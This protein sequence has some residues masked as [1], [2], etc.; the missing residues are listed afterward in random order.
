MKTVDQP[1]FAMEFRSADGLQKLPS[2]RPSATRAQFLARHDAWSPDWTARC[3]WG[4]TELGWKSTTLGQRVFAAR[5]PQGYF[6]GPDL[7]LLEDAGVYRVHR[8]DFFTRLIFTEPS[9]LRQEFAWGDERLS[10]AELLRPAGEDPQVDWGSLGFPGRPLFLGANAAVRTGGSEVLAYKREGSVGEY[11]GT[12]GPGASGSLTFG[13][14][15]PADF[16]AEEVTLLGL[17]RRG[18]EWVL[19]RETGCAPSRLVRRGAWL[20]HG[21]GSKPET[22]FIATY[23]ADRRDEVIRNLAGAH[24]G[25]VVLSNHLGGDGRL[26]PTADTEVDALGLNVQAWMPW[27]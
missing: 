18:I 17:V 6:N 1:P 23:D 13:D 12:V 22:S 21:R 15:G 11:G 9:I 8:T 14:L 16:E 25:A 19:R 10:V 7:L 26:P 3:A 27:V 4:E 20:D 24:A 5:A 2:G